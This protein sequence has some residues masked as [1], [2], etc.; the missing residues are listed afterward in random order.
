M[1]VHAGGG[2]GQ[3]V[4][5]DDPQAVALG[6]PK[7]QGLNGVALEPD[8]DTGFA[9]AGAGG[10]IGGFFLADAGQVFFQDVHAALGVVVEEAVEG[11]VDLDGGDVVGADRRALGAAGAGGH[12]FSVQSAG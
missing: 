10:R 8:G 9:L 7:R 2:L 1:D 5:E 6:N 4:A 3:S 12:G 11:D